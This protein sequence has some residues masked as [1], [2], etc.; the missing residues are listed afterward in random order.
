MKRILFGLAL[1]LALAVAP[2]AHA[3]PV[4]SC[5]SPIIGQIVVQTNGAWSYWLAC[6]EFPNQWFFVGVGTFWWEEDSYTFYDFTGNG[7]PKPAGDDG[8]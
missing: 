3:S 8:D 1:V 2:K 7:T 5:G 6:S 4:S